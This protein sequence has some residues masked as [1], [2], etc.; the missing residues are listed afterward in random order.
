MGSR[1]WGVELWVSGHIFFNWSLIKQKRSLYT[2]GV[3]SFVYFFVFTMFNNL[4]KCDLNLPHYMRSEM[5]VIIFLI[6]MCYILLSLSQGS[7]GLPP[8]TRE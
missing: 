3:D 4:T 7:N 8:S 2:I 5:H 1:S 6:A